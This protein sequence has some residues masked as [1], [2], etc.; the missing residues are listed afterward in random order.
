MCAS[1]PRAR[2]RGTGT[3]VGTRVSRTCEILPVIYGYRVKGEPL[4]S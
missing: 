4:A 3:E 2:V 1:I